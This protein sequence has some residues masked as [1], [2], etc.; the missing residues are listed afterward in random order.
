MTLVGIAA[1]IAT[2]ALIGLSAG[3]GFYAAQALVSA[4]R[5]H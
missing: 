3:I 1:L 4:F 2:G 5:K